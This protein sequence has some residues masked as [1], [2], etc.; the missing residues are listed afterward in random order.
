[1]IQYGGTLLK[2][3]YQNPS[4]GCGR[5]LA[6]FVTNE[7]MCVFDSELGHWQEYDY[8]LPADHGVTPIM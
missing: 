4:Y 1:M 3:D 7:T 2:T 8:G 6:F 5:N